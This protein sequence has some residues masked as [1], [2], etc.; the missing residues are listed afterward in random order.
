MKLSNTELNLL[1]NIDIQKLSP[2]FLRK[3]KENWEQ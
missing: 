1:E 2:F 3:K